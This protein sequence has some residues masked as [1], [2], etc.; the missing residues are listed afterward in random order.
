MQYMNLMSLVKRIQEKYPLIHVGGSFGLML[1]GINLG[2]ELKDLDFCSPVYIKMPEAFNKME[3]TFDFN[4][5]IYD[6]HDFDYQG[7]FRE[8]FI[9]IRIDDTQTYKLINRSGFIFKVTDIEIIKFYKQ[10]YAD[11]GYEK[12]AKDIEIIDKFLKK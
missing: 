5:T 11:K 2:R 12:H 4:D 9:E 7:V 6:T 10:K 1:H 8:V 3:R